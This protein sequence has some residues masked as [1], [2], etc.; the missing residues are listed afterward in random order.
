MFKNW[1]RYVLMDQASDDGADGGGTPAPAVA[2]AAAAPAAAP[3]AAAAEPPATVLQAAAPAEPKGIPE[4]YQV[5][6]EDGTLNL[7]A[8]SLKLAEAYANAEKRIGSGDLPPKTAGE[9]EIKVPEK[10]AGAWDPAADPLM[11]TFKEKALAAGFTQAQMDLVVETYGDI[12][13][14]LVAG[15][16]A[17]SAEE[18]TADLKQTWKTEA[19]F[20]DGTGAAARALKAYGGDES[21]ALL[22]KY[23]NDPALIRFMSRVGNEVAEDKSLDPGQG[24]GSDTIEQLEASKAYRDPSDPQHAN[25]SAKVR[26]YYEAKAA[27]DAKAGNIPLM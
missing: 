9:Y 6:N 14:G 5:K 13:P 16:V 3:A 2:P 22:T 18:C 17:L 20:K 23:G 1:I 4:K 27:Q 7:E 12:A 15:T 8:S 25:V 10:L 11:D 24:L 26:Q 19:E 21:E